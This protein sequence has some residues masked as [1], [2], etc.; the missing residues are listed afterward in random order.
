MNAVR[1]T[2]P[3]ETVQQL[4]GESEVARQLKVLNAVYIKMF[5]KI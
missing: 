4:Q 3:K 1:L 5:I 2:T